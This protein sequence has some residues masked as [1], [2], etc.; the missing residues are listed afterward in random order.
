MSDADTTSELLAALAN[1]YPSSEGQWINLTEVPQHPQQGGRRIDFLAIH[2]WGSRGYAHHGHEIKASRSDW[3]RELKDPSKADP[4]IRRCHRW[5]LVTPPDVVQPGELPDTWG[6]LVL[7]GS[8]LKVE[9]DATKL[10][11]PPPLTLP[12]LVAMLRS[13]GEA[14]PGALMRAEERGYRRGQQHGHREAQAGHSDRV[15][16]SL[17]SRLAEVRAFTEATGGLDPLNQ[18]SW[19][20]WGSRLT[21]VGP[22]VKLLLGAAS[23]MQEAR[24][25]VQEQLN[26]LER[27]LDEARAAIVESEAA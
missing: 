26:V 9:T 20:V 19:G 15:V 8:K 25:R 23:P 10:D 24:A 13:A 5:W 7:R 1:R 12:Q 11:P 16:E 6:H 2:T 18:R 17:R 3:L 4:W 22:A 21:E 14:G 27:R